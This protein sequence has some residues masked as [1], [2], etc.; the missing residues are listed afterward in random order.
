[1]TGAAPGG[2]LLS[3]NVSVATQLSF[4]INGT[5]VNVSL[6]V[7][8]AITANQIA[9]SIVAEI[10]N[11][12]ITGVTAYTLNGS[13]WVLE[14]TGGTDLNLQ[15]SF[16]A[17][18]ASGIFSIGGSVI[19]M[20]GSLS[21]MWG[22]SVAGTVANYNGQSSA[23]AK[24]V[25]IN[26]VQG[27]SNVLATVQP[28]AVTGTGVIAA[29][30]LN[31]GDVHINGQDIGAVTVTASD[32]TG[33]LAA[34]INNLQATTGVTASVNGNG[35][36]VLTAADGRNITVTTSS[37]AIGTA[38]GLS[39]TATNGTYIYR[40][41]IKLSDNGNIALTSPTDLFDLTGAHGTS[42]TIAAS[43]ATYNVAGIKL[44]TQAHAQE[45]ILTVDSALQQVDNINAGIGAIQNRLQFTVN[46]L[47]VA[48]ENMSSSESTIKD[49]DFASEVATFTRNQ[50]MVQAGVAM[51][52]Q[53][54][55]TSQYA[56]Q[57]LR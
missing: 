48:S 52:A 38:L 19:G 47:Q 40:S 26:A 56:L 11:A 27:T 22:N 1:L 5:A 39:G 25:A 3:T 21:G 18:T 4:L 32:G 20:T 6:A 57:L 14:G 42:Q 16:L 9:A 54:N 35:Q 41:A 44:D 45:A 29:T 8:T 37:A 50:I 53:A 10:N 46:S 43:V 13:Q 34:A 12:N 23:I 55:T 49:A 33:A 15:Y 24:A 17:G 28:N 7:S 36:L 30:A 51:V 2:D 31:S